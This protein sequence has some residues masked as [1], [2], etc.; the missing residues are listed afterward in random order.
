VQEQLHREPLDPARAMQGAITSLEEQVKM[1][2]DG[3]GAGRVR[4]G[5]RTSNHS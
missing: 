1:L 2:C 5:R 4:S 3:G